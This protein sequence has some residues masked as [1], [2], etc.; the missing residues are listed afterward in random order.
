LVVTAT[1]LIIIPEIGYIKDIYVYE[2]RRANTMFKL[3]YQAFIMYSLAAGYIIVRLTSALKNPVLKN[4]YKV[5][6]F[7]VFVAHMIYP[8]FSIKSFYSTGQYQ[9]LDGLAYLQKMY[10]DNYDAI[11]WVDQNIKGQPVMIEASGDS[12]TTYNHIS[13]ATGLPTIQGWI[14]H[15]WLWRGGYDKP[16]AR[17][18]EVQTIYTSDNTAEIRGIIQKYN[19]QYIFVGAKEYEKYPK[20]D[21]DKFEN[22]GAK[23]VFQSGKTRI[24][25]I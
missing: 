14:V 15:E 24:Y 22:L 7:L 25:K 2:Y 10:P 16:A 9:G 1:A 17:A 11:L 18:Q 23:I 5:L 13:V 21:P 20:L 8:Y 19:V 6:F 12:Y 3:V 4:G